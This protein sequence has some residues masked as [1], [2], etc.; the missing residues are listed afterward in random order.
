MVLINTV[1][2]LTIAVRLPYSSKASKTNSG[3]E[4]SS[5][6]STLGYLL[7]K[8][9]FTLNLKKRYRTSQVLTLLNKATDTTMVSKVD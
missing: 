9:I 5:G 1:R 4:T 8:A 7:R 2:Q 6:I 3:H